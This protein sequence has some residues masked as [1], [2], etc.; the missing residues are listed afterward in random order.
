MAGSETDNT[1]TEGSKIVKTTFVEVEHKEGDT[2]S[3]WYYFLRS[4]NKTLGQCKTCKKIIKSTGGT[5]TGLI[6]HL[7]S[8]HKIDLRKLKNPTKEGKI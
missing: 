7:R 8:L 5:T 3:V 6:T 4:D 2:T 1:A